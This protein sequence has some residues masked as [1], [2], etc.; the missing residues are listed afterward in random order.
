MFVADN[1]RPAPGGSVPD[2]F[3]WRAWVPPGTLLA[4]QAPVAEQIDKI[5]QQR[6]EM[7]VSHFSRSGSQHAAL[8][9]GLRLGE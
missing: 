9:P 8:D 1:P 5:M 7:A 3:T 2:N 4:A 6:L